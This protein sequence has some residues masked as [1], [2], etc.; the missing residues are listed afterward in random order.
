MTILLIDS[1]WDPATSTCASLRKEKYLRE[2][3]FP[4]HNF[5]SVSGSLATVHGVFRKI[6]NNISYISAQGHGRPSLFTGDGGDAIFRSSASDQLMKL[7][8]KIVHLLSCF[9]AAELGPEMVSKGVKAFF[10][11]EKD[12]RFARSKS[13]SAD[14]LTDD[15]ASLFLNI[16]TEVDRMV[17]LGA[18]AREVHKRV[19]MLYDSAITEQTMINQDIAARLNHNM[20]YFRSPEV[21]MLWG[22][23]Q[24][25][26]EHVYRPD[27][28]PSLTSD[29]PVLYNVN[30][31]DWNRPA[32]FDNDGNSVPLKNI[33]NMAKNNTIKK[34]SQL[35]LAEKRKLAALRIETKSN[36]WEEARLSSTDT[37]NI[38]NSVRS[39]LMDGEMEM[40]IS[41][42]ERLTKPIIQGTHKPIL[43]K[44][45]ELSRPVA[46]CT[47]GELISLSKYRET[48]AQNTTL[49]LDTLGDTQITELILARLDYWQEDVEDAYLN[50]DG[51]LAFRGKQELMHQ[52]EAQTA[53]GLELIKMERLFVSRLTSQVDN[54]EVII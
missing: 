24:A 23:K 13:L 20:R 7:S 9:T 28:F 10:G 42:I 46:L 21:D 19:I 43:I 18:T 38:A 52:V 51:Y 5:S 3:S 22:D 26:L 40:E 32:A 54:S 8:S 15:I 39:G 27:P 48:S 35:S 45:N 25:R 44:K 34:S 11:Y 50:N 12:F 47:N 31:A 37:I 36:G 53:E 17:L 41:F 6:S 16:A 2:T 29:T 4:E 30:E 14:P 33:Y 1:D 49:S